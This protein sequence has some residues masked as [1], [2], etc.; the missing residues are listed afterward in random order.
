MSKKLILALAFGIASCKNARVQDENI[1]LREIYQQAYKEFDK[2]SYKKAADIFSKAYFM[3]P[4]KSL[5]AEIMEAYSLYKLGQ[6]QEAVDIIDEFM[7]LHPSYKDMDYVLYLKITCM[8]AQSSIE[9]YSVLNDTLKQTEYFLIKYPR[10]EHFA[11][12]SEMQKSILIKIATKEIKIGLFY[13]GE[14][15]PVA[16]I[17]R[18]NNS[19]RILESDQAYYNLYQAYMMLGLLEEAKKSSLKIKDSH[20]KKRIP[21]FK[22]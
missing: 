1:P 4:G 8:Y 11:A 5:E 20:I 15:N 13:L 22:K 19:L 6:Y 16:A 21:I 18:F 2:K 14:K 9:E 10:S 7:F 3:Y 12:M 17:N